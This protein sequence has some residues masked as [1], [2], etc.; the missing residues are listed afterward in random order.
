MPVSLIFSINYG[1]AALLFRVDSLPPN[2][3][4]SKRKGFR[5]QSNPD[6]GPFFMCSCGIATSS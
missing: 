4:K 1:F 5:I 6:A 3:F 2:S